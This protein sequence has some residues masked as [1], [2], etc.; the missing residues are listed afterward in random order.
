GLT[1]DPAAV[2][3]EAVLAAQ[4]EPGLLELE[5]LVRRAVDGDLLLVALTAARAALADAAASGRGAYPRGGWGRRN[6]NGAR[7]GARLLRFSSR[8]SRGGL[9]QI[10]ARRPEQFGGARKAHAAGHRASTSFASE[11]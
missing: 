4:R 10:R 11:R 3:R 8:G 5:Q 7:R 2:H 9:V 6:R 1:H